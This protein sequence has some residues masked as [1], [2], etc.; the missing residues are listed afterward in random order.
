MD[1]ILRREIVTNKVACRA[2]G[3]AAFTVASA[4]GAY[5][6]IPLPF[7]PVPLTL[8]TFF[9]LLSGAAL[10]G[11]MGAVAQASYIL[12]G[13]MGLSVFSGASSGPGY[14][15]GP[16]GGYLFG[17]VL[18]AVFVG[19][20]LRFRRGGFPFVFGVFSLGAMIILAAGAVWL[21]F[22]LGCSLEH[23]VWLGLMPFIPGDLIKVSVVSV[24]YLKFEPR[25]REVF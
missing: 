13:V 19:R 20:S 2:L 6:R 9:V 23:A 8:Q 17:F 4:L 7:T 5:V 11:R 24:L 12:L 10:G 18:A 16:T 1:T 15:L 25:L 22:L 3:I 21:K 14:L